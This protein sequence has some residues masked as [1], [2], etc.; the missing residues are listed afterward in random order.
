MAFLFFFKLTAVHHLGFLMQNFH[1]SLGFRVGNNIILANF[2]AIAS[3]LH[4]LK[5]F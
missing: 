3:V 2:I 1:V 4:L 5:F